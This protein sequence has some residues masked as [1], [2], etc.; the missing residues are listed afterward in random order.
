[1]LKHYD[2][3]ILGGGC[4]GLSLATRLSRQG[5]STPRTLVL[6]RRPQYENDRTW[7]F[8]ELPGSEATDL[9]EHRWNRFH[10][11]TDRQHVTP[12][13]SQM[14]YCA[15]S[16]A[17]FYNYSRYLI[18]MSPHV[19]LRTN[20]AVLGEIR[21]SGTRWE[22]RT[23]QGDL[24][25]A[26]IV[27]TRPRR[28]PRTGDAILWQ[29]FLGAEV[30]F[31]SPCL[32]AGTVTLM[33]F[34]QSVPG[35]ILFTYILPYTPL[36]GLIEVTEFSPL[37]QPPAT[38]QPVLD[39]VLRELSQGR[40][41]ETRRTEAGALPMGLA[42]PLSEPSEPHQSYVQAGV[43]AGGARP[44]TG[45]AF[46]RIQRWSDRCAAS[47]LER[48]LPLGNPADPPLLAMLDH[49]FLRVLRQYPDRA[50]ALFAQ[51]FANAATPSVLRFL[52]DQAGPADILNVV[53]A[54]PPAMF[55]KELLALGGE[56]SSGWI[57]SFV[58]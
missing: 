57:E 24:S 14:P 5:G 7:C 51:L 46:Q 48:G 31:S 9:V 44:A 55:V 53:S 45:Y 27:D 34:R 4:A 41:F 50:P 30:C 1:M 52:G 28:E 29:T 10:I 42:P 20:V 37:A 47:V 40:S 33:D 25:A 13:C 32:E 36:R 56:R 11:Q 58:S 19:D 54:L 6:E 15:I 18:E 38:L 26:L 16:A 39:R 21:R 8:W 23:D 35:R 17:R 12:D 22:V 43:R 2:L 3:I 49:V